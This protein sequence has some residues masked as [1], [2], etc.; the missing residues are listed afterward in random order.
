MEEKRKG[1]FAK[2][3]KRINRK[4]RPHKG[5][6]FAE[7]VRDALE[8]PDEKSGRRKVDD[9]ID[10]AMKRALKGQFQFWD[11]LTARGYGKVPEKVEMTTEQKVDLSKLTT[12]E[13]EMLK[14][15]MEKAKT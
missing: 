1:Q 13:I 5:L 11:A 7:W 2:G 10:E 3:D 9:L 12:E 15:L 6:T 4:G 14:K 8:S